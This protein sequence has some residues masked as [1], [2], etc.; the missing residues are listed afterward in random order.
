MPLGQVICHNVQR[1]SVI[2]SGDRGPVGAGHDRFAPPRWPMPQR[3]AF[4]PVQAI[5][6]QLAHDLAFSIQEDPNFPLPGADTGLG[7]LP[8]SLAELVARIPVT[9]IAI[10]GPRTA[11]GLTSTAFNDRIGRTQVLRHDPLLRGPYH[12]FTNPSCSIT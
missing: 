1:P 6:Q 3:Q 4:F 11:D 5:D 9:A 8:D 10:I 2:R 7:H 12:F